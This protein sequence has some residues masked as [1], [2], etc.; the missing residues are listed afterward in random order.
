[1]KKL[2]D[3]TLLKKE[4]RP[5]ALAAGFFDGLHVGHQKVLDR[6]VARAREINGKAWALTFDTHPL[7]ILDPDS[8]PPLLTSNRHKLKLLAR[9]DLD[10]CLLAPFT[11][12]L[13]GLEP[14]DFVARLRECAPTLAEILVGRNWRFGR[15]RKGDTDLLSR[16]GQEMNFRVT[17]IRPV[18]RRGRAVS[19]TRIRNEIR[20]GRLGEAALLLGRPFSI[21]GTVTGGTT[22]GRRL[23]FPTANLDSH[24]EVVPALGVYA[25][26]ALLQKNILGGVVNLGVRPTFSKEN[27]AKPVIEVHLFD[28]DSELYGRDIEIFFVQKLRNERKFPSEETLKAQIARD[29]TNARRLL[30]QKKL[31][32]RFTCISALYY[33]PDRKKKTIKQ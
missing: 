21:L 18:L 10:G 14:V 3:L 30:A 5:I 4:R 22:R 13:A 25:V 20:R 27:N 23:G 6:T 8:A 2:T 1:M 32:N 28:L 19:S 11:R 7:K 33:S 17:L 26:Y 31:K 29:V 24:G 15:K 9:F 16:L 12:E